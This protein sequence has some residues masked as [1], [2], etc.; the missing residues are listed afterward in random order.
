[1]PWHNDKLVTMTY[2]TPH[3]QNAHAFIEGVGWKK[4]RTGATDGVT[5]SFLALSAAKANGRR[6]SVF[7]DDGDKTL[8]TVYLK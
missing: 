5:N 3:S 4:V 2:A 6:V 7:E 8:T 1:M